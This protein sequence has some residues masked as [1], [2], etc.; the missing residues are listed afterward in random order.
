MKNNDELLAFSDLKILWKQKKIRIFRWGIFSALLVFLFFLV[1]QPKYR[2]SGKFKESTFIQESNTSDSLRSIFQNILSQADESGGI[3]L[4]RS[5]DFLGKVAED[6]GLQMQFQKEPFLKRISCRMK[7]SWSA[8]LGKKLKDKE[9]FR[10]RNVHYGGEQTLTFK[11]SFKDNENF[12]ARD[13]KNVCL[14]RGKLKEEIKIGPAAF[15]LD[16]AP[17]DLCFDRPYEISILPMQPVLDGL[18][19]SLKI[20]KNKNDARIIEFEYSHRDRILA[21][22]LINHV[23]HAYKQFLIEESE[24]LAQAQLWYLNDR[25]KRI[26]EE[27]DQNLQEHMVHL[28]KNIGEK[29]FINLNSE[30]NYLIESKAQYENSLFDINLQMNHLE[31][32]SRGNQ[33]GYSF[34]EDQDFKFQ[35]K[36]LSLHLEKESLELAKFR[37]KEKVTKPPYSHMLNALKDLEK[38]PFQEALPEVILGKKILSLRQSKDALAEGDFFAVPSAEN[39]HKLHI[40][41]NLIQETQALLEELEKG[42]KPNIESSPLHCYLKPLQSEEAFSLEDMLHYVRNFLRIK[43]LE[44]KIYSEEIFL[45]QEGKQEFLGIDL[46]TARS[47]YAD[48]VHRLDQIQLQIKELAHLKPK[49]PQQDF[50]P[51]SLY[52]LMD[53]P[54]CHE[55]IKEASHIKQQLRE[56]CYLSEKDKQ[57]LHQHLKRQKQ[58]ICHHMQQKSQLMQIEKKL[59]QRKISQL[60]SAML[61]LI[62]R[63]ISILEKQLSDYKASKREKLN[64]EKEYLIK[65]LDQMRQ[66][67]L[68]VPKKWLWENKLRLKAN[69]NMNMM[70]A[71]T[72][73]TE[74][75]NIEHHLKQIQSKPLESA[76]LPIKPRPSYAFLFTVLGAAGGLVLSFAFYLIAGLQKGLSISWETLR[77]TG[78]NVFGPISA[79]VQHRKLADLTACDLEVLRECAYFVSKAKVKEQGISVAL[80]EGGKIACGPIFSSLL[81]LASYRILL[82]DCSFQK[83]KNSKEE[84]GLWHFLHGEI[85]NCPIQKHFSYDFL[86][87]GKKSRFG[88]ELLQK[89]QFAKFIKDMKLH[90]DFIILCSS[91]KAKTAAAKALLPQADAALVA[92]SEETLEDL[93]EYFLWEEAHPLGFLSIKK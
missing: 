21:A 39:I 61:S 15:T 30:L 93:N 53:D 54:L 52:P 63:E 64:K 6:L 14:G 86:P 82:I 35:D 23:M 56:E 41:R 65:K 75:K 59:L 3:S 18:Q 36:I 70:E 73:L 19:N 76:Y 46:A 87:A 69:L 1:Q 49:I 37:Q 62:L 80:I 38:K 68:D 48:Y 29:G 27:L 71:L 60:Q 55:L 4:M 42:R 16:Q 12:E 66:D 57:R 31:N 22:A 20:K 72:K 88:L 90:Y 91:E 79:Q 77:R 50:E 33:E 43:K 24:K 81:A 67:S 92:L 9:V 28:E 78:K 5:R 44:E 7:E 2:T 84:L 85:K 11:L 40:T 89:S 10:A 8:M 58:S 45:D 32:A 17:A 13:E 83:E 26:E 51:S 34:F 47:L 74:T 25:R